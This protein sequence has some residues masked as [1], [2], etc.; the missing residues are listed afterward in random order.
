MSYYNST[1]TEK[2]YKNS[3]LRNWTEAGIKSAPSAFETMCINV[4]NNITYLCPIALDISGSASNSSLYTSQQLP[5]DN[6]D[7]T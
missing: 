1:V 7:N 2:L 3:Q 6:P 5:Q 4:R